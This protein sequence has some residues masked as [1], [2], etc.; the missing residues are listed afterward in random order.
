MISCKKS[1]GKEKIKLSEPKCLPVGTYIVPKGKEFYEKISS[2]VEGGT[3]LYTLD[4]EKKL[5]TNGDIYKKGIQITNRL[6][7]PIIRTINTKEGYINSDIIE[8]HYNY[9]LKCAYDRGPGLTVNKLEENLTKLEGKM[10]FKLKEDIYIKVRVK[11]KF[12][13]VKKYETIEE[14]MKWSLELNEPLKKGDKVRITACTKDYV[15]E[16]ME[17]KTEKRRNLI[18]EWVQFSILSTPDDTWIPIVKEIK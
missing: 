3:I 16:F 10:Q 17:V 4:D 8:R 11:N 7:T 6:S 2:D 1:D 5:V 15:V 14:N 13:V 9:I 12:G 18:I